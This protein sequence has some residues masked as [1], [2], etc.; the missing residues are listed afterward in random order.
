[1]SDSKVCDLFSS[2]C[3]AGDGWEIGGG[4]TGVYGGA[5]YTPARRVA[6]VR[7]AFDRLNEGV[8]LRFLFSEKFEGGTVSCLLCY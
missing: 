3:C 8:V 1:M 5:F 6:L 2:V 7:G 4:P